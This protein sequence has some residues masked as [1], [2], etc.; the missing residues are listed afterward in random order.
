MM[1]FLRSLST[2]RLLTLAAAVVALTALVA[3]LAVAAVGSNSAAPPPAALPNAIHDALSGPA[4][5][6]VTARVT[7][8]NKLFPSGALVGSA[9]PVLMSGGSGRL[10]MTNDGRGRLELQSSAGDAQIVWTPTG[11]TLY[12]ASSDTAYHASLPAVTADPAGPKDTPPTLARISELIAHL[13]AHATVSGA[14]PGVVATRP[15]YTVTV[16]PKHDGGLLGSVELAWD[17]ANG[18]PLRIAVV[19]QGSTSPALEL[20]VTGVEYGPV[21]DANVDIKPPAS[22]KVVDLGAPGSKQAGSA[23]HASISGLDAVQAA[24]SF[25]VKAPDTLVGLPRRDVRLTGGTDAGSQAVVVT[26]G[27]GLGAIVVI[28][29]AASTGGKDAAPLTGLPTVSLDG[30][31]AHELATQ[32]GT[33]V[34]WDRDGVSTVLAGSVP[35]AAAEA[36]ARELG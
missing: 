24:A 6:G 28:E 25:T 5:T 7:F 35:A 20:A 18:V 2:T 36:A 8:T 13:G 15:A 14:D 10:W 9:G 26:Y 16:S 17:A 27:Q 23:D 31:T 1:R 3:V 12:D 29:R 11:V 19:A 30:A 33:I 4:P 22:A 21:A 32:L 34:T